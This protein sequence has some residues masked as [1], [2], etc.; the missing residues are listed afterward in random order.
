MTMEAHKHSVITPAIGMAAIV[1]EISVDHATTWFAKAVVILI[2]AALWVWFC[3][4]MQTDK[5]RS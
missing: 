1:A 4:R 3:R 2:A 5:S